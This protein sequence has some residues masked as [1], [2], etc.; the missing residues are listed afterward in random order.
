[1]VRRRSGRVI[2]GAEQKTAQALGEMLEGITTRTNHK[3][4]AYPTVN[5]TSTKSLEPAA[6]RG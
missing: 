6:I 5:P 3:G 2:E 1:M 4:Q